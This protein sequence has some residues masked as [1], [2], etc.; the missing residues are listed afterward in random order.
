MN[1]AEFWQANQGAFFDVGAAVWSVRYVGTLSDYAANIPQIEG[2]FRKHAERRS[3]E[4]VTPLTVVTDGGGFTV[5]G[6]GVRN[7]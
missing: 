7:G 4:L 5:Y 6:I 2:H 3:F 1:F